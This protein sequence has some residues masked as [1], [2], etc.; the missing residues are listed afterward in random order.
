MNIQE[1]Q[2]NLPHRYPLLMV[3]RVVELQPG[4]YIRA[5]KN[6]S[7]N[8][9]VFNGH[10]PDFPIFPGVLTI[11]AMAQACGILGH[12]TLAMEKDI[13]QKVSAY[14]LVSVDK[15]RFHHAVTPGDRLDLEARLI[16][17]KKI[18]WRFDC[19]SKVDGKKVCSA[20]I[21]CAEGTQNN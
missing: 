8:E 12:Q 3:D 16:S 19:I 2:N 9:Q 13:D 20:E 18:F 6:I 14:L 4:E 10:F 7:I 21:L 11:E 1:I 5:Y 17:R 15:A